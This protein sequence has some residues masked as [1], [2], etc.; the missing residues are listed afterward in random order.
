[1][2]RLEVLVAALVGIYLGWVVVA[3]LRSGTIRYRS[4]THTRTAEPKAYWMVVGW[5]GLLALIALAYAMIAGPKVL[6]P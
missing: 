1:M 4:R 2:E 5:F 3:A 6:F